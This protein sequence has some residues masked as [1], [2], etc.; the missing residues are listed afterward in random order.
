MS[1]FLHVVDGTPLDD[2][3]W[4][5]KDYYE[6][7]RTK[8]ANLETGPCYEIAEKRGLPRRLC[9]TPMKARTQY[10]PRADYH[11]SSLTSIIKPAS[12]GYVPKNENVAL[13][14]GP[15]AHNSCFD[16]PEGE[17]D[18]FNV[19]VGRRQLAD[20]KGSIAW[21]ATSN[22][23][24]SAMTP[25]EKK[26]SKTDDNVNTRG[27]AGE[28]IVPGKG[29]EISG[30]PQGYCDGTYNSVCSRSTNEECILTG[31]QVG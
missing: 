10:T 8:V 17:I 29:W 22:I 15:D 23:K 4:H 27:L 30:E 5:V 16:I 9:N 13:Y 12:D 25:A 11:K 24:I 26:S 20:E 6:K 1:L 28:K 21:T 14:D 18:V 19:V 31:R 7:I 2:D 3:V